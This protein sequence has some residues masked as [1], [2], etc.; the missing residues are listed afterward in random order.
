M[1]FSKRMA[2]GSASSVEGSIR[3]V[4]CAHSNS[5][6]Y[7][8]DPIKYLHYRT[9][10][11]NAGAGGQSIFTNTYE[12]CSGLDYFLGHLSPQRMQSHVVSNSTS[13]H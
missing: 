13:L 7:A 2:E 10:N 4:Y 11:I 6:K 1:I 12:T 9:C 8:E 3:G 5:T